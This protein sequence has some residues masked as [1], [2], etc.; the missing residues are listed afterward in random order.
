MLLLSLFFASC[1]Q[2]TF[3]KHVDLM[4]KMA[5]VAEYLTDNVAEEAAEN[6]LAKARRLAVEKHENCKEMAEALS[7]QSPA[8]TT[9]AHPTSPAADCLRNGDGATTPESDASDSD[10]DNS[11]E[12]ECADDREDVSE[13]DESVSLSATF[14]IATWNNHHSK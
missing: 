11:K 13:S 6:N 14:R 8:P 3:K 1:S 2:V 5:V 4:A 12:S 7:R 10:S 9:T